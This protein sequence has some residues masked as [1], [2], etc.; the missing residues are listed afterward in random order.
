M[1]YSPGARKR[2]RHDLVIKP[3]PSPKEERACL[4]TRCWPCSIPLQAP[5]WTCPE[6]AYP[7]SVRAFRESAGRHK[8]GLASSLFL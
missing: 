5:L 7:V 6:A 8:A 4:P 3:P 1:G 2:I